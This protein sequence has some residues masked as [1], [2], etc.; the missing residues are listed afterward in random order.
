MPSS[1]TI[2]DSESHSVMTLPPIWLTFSTAYWATLP[3]PLIAT[4]LFLKSRPRVASISA[5][6]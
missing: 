6:K 4:T 5:A 3:D 1:S 2:V